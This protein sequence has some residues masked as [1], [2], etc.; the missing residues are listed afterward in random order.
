MY[1]DRTCYKITRSFR[2]SSH[3]GA[4]RPSMAT[5][6]RCCPLSRRLW[7]R[8]LAEP[9]MVSRKRPRGIST[10]TWSGRLVG[11][12]SMKDP[13]WSQSPRAYGSSGWCVSLFFM[14]LES[15]Y[16]K[17]KHPEPDKWATSLR[18]RQQQQAECRPL[19]T[20]RCHKMPCKPEAL[21]W[22][23]EI[24]SG[25][26]NVISGPCLWLQWFPVPPHCWPGRPMS[27]FEETRCSSSWAV[28]SSTH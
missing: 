18:S 6:P 22:G 12:W 24:S 1:S 21:P 4:G 20:P 8:G 28:R 7:A 11:Q 19:N 16:V 25:D 9:P 5:V 10:A 3:A 13:R 2:K 15:K 26:Q 23:N 14:F 27:R 17:M